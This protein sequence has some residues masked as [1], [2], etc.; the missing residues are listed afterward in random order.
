M[1]I[2]RCK[3]CKPYNVYAPSEQEVKSLALF[4]DKSQYS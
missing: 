2:R 3:Y 4:I 1:H